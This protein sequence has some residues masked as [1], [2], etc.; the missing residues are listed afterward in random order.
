MIGAK[1][2]LNNDKMEFKE[3]IYRSDKSILIN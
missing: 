1:I 3:R 2:Q